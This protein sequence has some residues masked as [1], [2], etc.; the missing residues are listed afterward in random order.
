MDVRNQRLGVGV[1]LN[2]QH[3]LHNENNNIIAIN[4]I[5]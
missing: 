4:K 5:M 1:S 3:Q 2:L